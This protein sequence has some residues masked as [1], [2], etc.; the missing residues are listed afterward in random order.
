MVPLISAMVVL[1]QAQGQPA[2]IGDP[3]AVAS[4]ESPVESAM[5]A[6]ASFGPWPQ[7]P[8]RLQIH[9]DALAFEQATKAPPQRGACWVGSTLHLRPWEQL[10]RRDLGAMLRHELVHRRLA[11]A[12]LRR[13]EEEAR[14]LWAETHVR[15]PANWPA[16]PEVSLQDR[17]DLALARG[18]TETQAWAY[19]WLRAWLGGHP[20]PPF[21]QPLA[22][23][24]PQWTPEEKS[25]AP[26]ARNA[27]RVRWPESRLPARM[28]IN[29]RE[30]SRTTGLPQV[31][32]G[33]VRFGPE[34]P[35]AGLEG[36]VEARW[37]G[38]GWSLVWETS[39]ATWVAAAVSGELGRAPFETKRALAAVLTRWLEGHRESQHPDGSLCPLTHCA[40]VRGQPQEEDLRAA[41]SAPRLGVDPRWVFFTGS[42]GGEALS[43]REVWGKGPDLKGQPLVVAGDRWASWE[44]TFTPRQVQR[45]KKSV[46]PGLA[47]G[48]KGLR[49]GPSGPYPVEDLRLAAGRSFGWT[50]WPSNACKAEQLANGDLLVKGRGWGHNVGLCLTTALELGRQGQTA[51]T[52]LKAAFPEE[53]ETGAAPPTVGVSAP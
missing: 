13:W 39:P 53:S 5:E 31:F 48:Q 49:L 50:A 19:R 27:V 21:P 46:R 3:E 22:Q 51:E 9:P 26:R 18:I 44:R 41:S 45:L 40:V 8:W 30:L 10:R 43:P 24:E 11:G 23:P 34:C 20:R 38:T 12:H 47:P 25:A 32:T 15:P 35:V 6:T 37:S 28:E 52:I 14:C 16:A 29:G 4:L 7:T 2:W 42:S 1:L 17:L 36:R 33:H